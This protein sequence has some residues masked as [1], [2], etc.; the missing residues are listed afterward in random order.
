MVSF[1][2]LSTIFCFDHSPQIMDELAAIFEISASAEPQKATSNGSVSCAIT[3]YSKY[4]LLLND[5]GTVT[6]QINTASHSSCSTHI[7]LPGAV[8]HHTIA[9]EGSGA[10]VFCFAVWYV[11]ALSND[12]T[13]WAKNR[14][15]KENLQYATDDVYTYII[16]IPG[17]NHISDLYIMLNYDS[18][19]SN[20]LI[21]AVK[22]EVS[23]ILSSPFSILVD[24]L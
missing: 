21:N 4:V 18:V 16:N 13:F 20:H 14:F 17:C 12:L 1:I 11:P 2:L 24:N 5:V 7:V 6:A 10:C 8:N 23:Q 15:I 9:V 19:K 3:N 22:L